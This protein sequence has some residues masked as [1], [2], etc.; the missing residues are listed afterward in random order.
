MVI[1]ELKNV[2]ARYIVQQLTRYYHRKLCDRH[3]LIFYPSR[4]YFNGDG[5]Y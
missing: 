5:F 1:I 4:Q 2:E 3:T